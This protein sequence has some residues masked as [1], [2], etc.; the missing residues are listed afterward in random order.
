MFLT[1]VV[2]CTRRYTRQN[3][4]RC[5][6]I[7]VSAALDEEGGKL[8][9][10]HDDIGDLSIRKGALGERL[11]NRFH[12]LLVRIHGLIPNRIRV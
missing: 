4:Q 1:S 10:G 5:S 8:P 2:R 7:L 6:Q 11:V 12:L 9:E 3:A